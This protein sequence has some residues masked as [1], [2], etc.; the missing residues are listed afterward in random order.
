MCSFFDFPGSHSSIYR[1]ITRIPL[2]LIVHLISVHWSFL[3]N[4]LSFSICLLNKSDVEYLSRLPSTISH[5]F[6]YQ[7]DVLLPTK[8]K[9]CFH[10]F[11]FFGDVQAHF[12]LAPTISCQFNYSS[13]YQNKAS[14]IRRKKRPLFILELQNIVRHQDKQQNNRK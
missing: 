4:V 1:T 6:L 11:L 8:S 14:P 5:D 12:A 7:Y 9:K 2:L 13:Y 3:D 10:A